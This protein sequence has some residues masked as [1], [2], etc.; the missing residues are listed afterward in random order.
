MKFKKKNEINPL[1]IGRN[2]C[3]IH[4][5]QV[6]QSQISQFKSHNISDRCYGALPNLSTRSGTRPFP[7]LK[8]L[9]LEW[10][11]NIVNIL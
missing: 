11:L 2:I 9:G 8:A 3:Q 6:S 4:I 5:T 7:K 1:N 10:V